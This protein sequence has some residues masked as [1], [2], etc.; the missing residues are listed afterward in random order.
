M[1]RRDRGKVAR[2]D[3]RSYSPPPPDEPSYH[4]RRQQRVQHVRPGVNEE[5]EP[6]YV[7]TEDRR[8]VAE[9]RR[10]HG[11]SEDGSRSLTPAM[12]DEEVDE[13]W[14]LAEEQEQMMMM[15]RRRGMPRSEWRGGG[16]G[17]NRSDVGDRERRRYEVSVLAT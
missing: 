6:P 4:N 8:G 5:G 1:Q 9:A 14:L 7:W 3:D 15:E 12:T 13:D 16:N 11:S 10:Y 17:R 2:G